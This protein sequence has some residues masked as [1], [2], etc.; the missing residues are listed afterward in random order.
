VILAG[1]ISIPLTGEDL[2]SSTHAN[3]KGFACEYM[4]AGRVVILGDPGPYAFSGM[5]GGQ[6]YQML[7]PVMGFDQ[8]ALRMRIALGAEVEIQPIDTSDVLQIQELLGYYLEALEQSF[9]YDMV[10]HVRFLSEEAM[11][12][13]RFVKVVPHRGEITPKTTTA[14]PT[15]AQVEEPAE[16]A[17]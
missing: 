7:S 2:Q 11:I 3:L 8:E 12:L 14:V 9:Q 5:T 16:A 4:T 1:E 6:V 10:D 13:D 15:T 17:S